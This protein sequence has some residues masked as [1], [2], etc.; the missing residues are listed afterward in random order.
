MPKDNTWHNVT[1]YTHLGL[2]LAASVLIFFFL[3]YW[4]DGKLGTE[5]LLALG[6][7]FIGAAGGFINLIRT[8]TNLQKRSER[9]EDTDRNDE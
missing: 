7:A 1:A 5:P 8:L 9:E 6:G 2:T 3:G 4:L